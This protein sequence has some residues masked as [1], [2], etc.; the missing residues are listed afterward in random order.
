MLTAS[1]LITEVGGA[2]RVVVAHDCHR[3]TSALNE[4]RVLRACVAVVAIDTAVK[5][6]A[7]LCIAAI[8]CA[9]VLVTAIFLF[10]D[11]ATG[12]G[13]T[14]ILRAFRTI[15]AVYGI[16]GTVTGFTFGIAVVDRALVSVFTILGSVDASF[17]STL[18]QCTAVTIVTVRIVEGTTCQ[19]IACV[20]AARIAIV[21]LLLPV[22]TALR[23]VTGV[24]RAR[25]VVIIAVNGRVGTAVVRKL[26]TL[27]RGA[28]VKGTGV[29]VRTRV[30]VQAGACLFVA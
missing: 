3:F 27:Y 25:V 11:A 23:G 26:V 14:D 10:V 8:L 28:R 5:A 30:D 6:A 21:A 16:E 17:G 20:L 15:T 4:A 22:A 9:V 12:F 7:R 18:V 13:V 19:R 24:N 1:G 29:V 2:G